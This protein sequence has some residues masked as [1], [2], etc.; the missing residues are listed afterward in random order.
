MKHIESGSIQIGALFWDFISGIPQLLFSQCTGLA[1]I[2]YAYNGP[3]WFV[4]ALLLGMLVVYFLMYAGEKYFATA[5]APALSL[6]C[7]GLV[8]IINGSLGSVHE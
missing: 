7:S 3:T 2:G 1:G 6:I 5:I 8:I 4:S